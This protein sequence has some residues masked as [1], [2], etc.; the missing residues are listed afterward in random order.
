M[1]KGFDYMTQA[2]NGRVP[3]NCAFIEYPF[4]SLL[5]ATFMSLLSEGNDPSDGNDFLFL[6][7]QHIITIYNDMACKMLGLYNGS[8]DQSTHNLSVYPKFLA[9]PCGSVIK[10]SD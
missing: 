5:D 10:S 6:A 9:T 8:D 4:Q 2:D 1:V 7:I 3:W